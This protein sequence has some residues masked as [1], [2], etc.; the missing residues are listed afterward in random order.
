MRGALT[1]LPAVGASLCV[2]SSSV[3][4]PVA[5]AS[6]KRKASLPAADAT[7]N[8]PADAPG[9]DDDG[10]DTSSSDDEEILNASDAEEEDLTPANLATLRRIKQKLAS[11][12]AAPSPANQKVT[13]LS[14]PKQLR[15]RPDEDDF[16]FTRGGGA[17][18]GVARTAEGYKVYQIGDLGMGKS[19]NTPLCPIDC[20]CCF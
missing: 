9:V 10:A 12:S 14:A 18:G 5:P 15:D 17:G 19:K 4:G 1:C 6:K 16:G 2:A 11:G 13:V 3:A 7:S 8:A 20:D